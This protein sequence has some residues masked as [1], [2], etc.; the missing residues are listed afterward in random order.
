M[1]YAT[2]TGFTITEET[3]ESE[4]SFKESFWVQDKLKSIDNFCDMISQPQK[5]IDLYKWWILTNQ[6]CKISSWLIQIGTASPKRTKSNIK[7]VNLICALSISVPLLL[8][9]LVHCYHGFREDF[10]CWDFAHNLAHISYGLIFLLLLSFLELNSASSDS[11]VGKRK[12]NIPYY[13]PRK[14]K[15]ICLWQIACEV[16][17]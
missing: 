7:M 15:R 9:D 5:G 3:F 17:L 11:L 14:N 12:T 10:E 16:L 8:L 13:V 6:N 2:L 4:E 1:S